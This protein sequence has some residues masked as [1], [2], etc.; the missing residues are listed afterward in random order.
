MSVFGGYRGAGRAYDK[1]AGMKTKFT[2]EELFG[3][4]CLWCNQHHPGES[5][6]DGLVVCSEC[7]ALVPKDKLTVQHGVR[8]NICKECEHDVADSFI[9]RYPETDN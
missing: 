1:G 2:L 5:C 9:I 8:W 7:F 4:A 3:P 6:R